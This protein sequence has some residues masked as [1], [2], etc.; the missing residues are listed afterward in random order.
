M[1]PENRVT[2]V[3][4]RPEV[5]VPSV[6]LP[7]ALRSR[8]LPHQRPPGQIA[9]P[10]AEDAGLTLWQAPPVWLRYRRSGKSRQSRSRSAVSNLSKTLSNSVVSVTRYNRYRARRASR[11][12]C[13]D[14]RNRKH[15][16][17]QPHKF[18][19]KLRKSGF[20]IIIEAHNE[21]R[22]LTLDPT[23]FAQSV[24]NRSPVWRGPLFGPTPYHADFLR[25]ARI[26]CES[27]VCQHHASCGN[28]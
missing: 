5:P 23:Q 26:L 14:A 4:R 12:R 8:Q 25:T 27:G 9:R 15:I 3:P 7:H 13:S 24:N 10:C 16:H 22:G 21:M 19:G 2:H 20:V 11:S 1:L 18:S 6:P 28:K 17:T